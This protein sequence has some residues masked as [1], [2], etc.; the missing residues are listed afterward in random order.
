MSASAQRRV[1]TCE[2]GHAEVR[3]G[4]PFVCPECGGVIASAARPAPAANDGEPLN[5]AELDKLTG[6]VFAR[7][8]ARRWLVAMAREKGDDGVVS[9]SEIRTRLRR[10]RE[11]WGQGALKPD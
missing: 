5:E 10:E 6:Q 1:R 4:D 7:V 8:E 9:L 11:R 3:D 2:C